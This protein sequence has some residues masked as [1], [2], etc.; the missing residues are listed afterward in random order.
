M[1]VFN[2]VD[3]ILSCSEQRQLTDIL[4]NGTDDVMRA[5][6]HEAAAPMVSR[7]HVKVVELSERHRQILYLLLEGKTNPEISAILQLTRKNVK[8]HIERIFA[9]LN[10]SNRTQAVARAVELDIALLPPDV[11]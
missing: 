8:Y 9:K 5:I 6:K 11:L 1:I 10:V 2:S 3:R 4:S 7:A